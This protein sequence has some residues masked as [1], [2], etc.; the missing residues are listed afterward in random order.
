M[1]AIKGNKEYTVDEK[2][3]AF[4]VDEG[5]D[6]LGDDGEV[7]AYGKGKTVPY[8]TYVSAVKRI[9]ILEGIITELRA[10]LEAAQQE[11][12]QTPDGDVIPEGAAGEP[13]EEAKEAAKKGK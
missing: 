2:Q 6:I 9:E 13:P 12:G 7:I 5:Y 3:K 8:E 10:E 4:Y 1:K 11:G